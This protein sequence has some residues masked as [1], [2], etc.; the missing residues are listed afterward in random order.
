MTWPFCVGH[1]VNIYSNM[2]RSLVKSN[3]NHF[4]RQLWFFSHIFFD[5][6]NFLIEATKKN[7]LSNK[8]TRQFQLPHRMI[9]KNS[10]SHEIFLN[11]CS[12]H[13]VIAKNR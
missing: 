13:V 2:L 12:K 7:C 10:S 3:V 6:Q 8:M 9:E 5:N 11:H 4:F 1:H